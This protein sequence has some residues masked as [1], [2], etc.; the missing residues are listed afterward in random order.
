M[1]TFCWRFCIVL[2]STSHASNKN[3]WH[4]YTI[5]CNLVIGLRVVWPWI[6]LKNLPRL[7]SP[8]CAST[9]HMGMGVQYAM[10]LWRVNIKTWRVQRGWWGPWN[11]KLG[12]ELKK[13]KDKKGTVCDLPVHWGFFSFA[14]SHSET[15]TLQVHK[16]SLPFWYNSFCNMSLSRRRGIKLIFAILEFAVNTSWLWICTLSWKICSLPSRNETHRDFLN[17][18]LCYCDRNDQL[19]KL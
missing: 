1:L 18:D 9:K 17:D 6:G 10:L 14:T 7:W 12:V 15:I 5:C 13:L 4:F 8:Q 19:Y 16:V 2:G 11:V 3:Y